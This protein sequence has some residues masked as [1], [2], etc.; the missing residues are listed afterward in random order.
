MATESAGEQQDD[1]QDQDD[2]DDRNLHSAWPAGGL[3]TTGPSSVRAMNPFT[4]LGNAGVIWDEETGLYK[5]GARYYD[6]ALGRFISPDPAEADPSLNSYAYAE[7]N[8]LTKADPAGLYTILIPGLTTNPDARGTAPRREKF[9]KR[10][11]NILDRIGSSRQERFVG[12]PWSR[13]VFPFV[14]K[15]RQG[16][17]P[18]VFRRFRSHL[19]KKCNRLEKRR[20]RV[21]CNA[22]GHSGGGMISAYASRSVPSLDFLMTLGSPLVRRMYSGGQFD[23]GPPKRRARFWI[24]V[25]DRHPHFLRFKQEAPKAHRDLR[26]DILHEDFFKKRRIARLAA[27]GICRG[28]LPRDKWR[29]S[30]RG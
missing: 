13:G 6:P 14:N 29:N 22:I 30:C 10:V 11:R 16:E 24:N 2:G 1:Q 7:N 25:R 23:L 15:I 18:G 9:R 27:F 28:R 4:F 17:R 20:P 8:P 21:S 5:M 26:S 12:F 3:E 19:L